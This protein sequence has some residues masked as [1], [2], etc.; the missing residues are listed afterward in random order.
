VSFGGAIDRALSVFFP[1]LAE[2]RAKARARFGMITRAYEAGVED[3]LSARR[4]R[5]E[6]I[7][8]TARRSLATTRAQARDLYRFNPYGHGLVNSTVAFVVGCGIRPQARVMRPRKFD[9]NVTFNDT[10]DSEWER[11]AYE[12]K[13]YEKERMVLREKIVAGECLIRKTAPK[14]R[15]IPLGLEVIKSERIA[16][17]DSEPKDGNRII[18]GVEV[19]SAG[20]PVAYHILPFDPSD[21]SVV[22]GI[23]PERVPADQ[24]LHIFDQLEPGQVRGL[25]R[26]L[27]CA[28]T[29]GNLAQ[30]QDFIL[31]KERLAGAFGMMVTQNQI[32]I[33]ETK[34]LTGESDTDDEGNQLAQLEGGM[35]WHGRPGESL[36]GVQ[37]GVQP[38][39]VDLLTTIFL[40]QFAVGFGGSYELISRD[41]SKV[42]YLSARQGENHD[43]RHW[44]PEQQNLIRDFCE[45]L[46]REFIRM[47]ALAGVI[48]VPEGGNLEAYSAVEWVTDGWDWID[49]SKDV[50]GDIEALKAG[51][52]SP[53]EATAKHGRDWYRILIEASAHKKEAEAQGL[54]LSIYPD[55][56][57]EAEA[58]AQ[59]EPAPMEPPNEQ[60]NGDAQE[61]ADAEAA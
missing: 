31:T 27:P 26:F 20:T 11:W 40:R 59:P 55:L 44:E 56:I 43:R 5:R 19:N 33:S 23:N 53:Q 57:A 61:G 39:Q 58:A 10:A 29:A 37:S 22:F 15:R 52:M 25:T 2:K 14:G 9:G 30:Y 1:G 13:F 42:T 34:V 24:I 32:G 45:P 16:D 8:Q 18:Q 4:V 28:G 47:G 35:F 48:P 38:A 51:L 50:A 54:T 46:W 49:P 41:L 12:E 17:L 21:N 3:R 7:V 36:T 6:S 60:T